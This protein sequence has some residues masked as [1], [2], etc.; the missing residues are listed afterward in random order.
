MVIGI[1]LVGSQNP[2]FSRLWRYWTEARSRNRTYLEYIAV[3]QRFVYWETALSIFGTDPWLGVGLGNYAFYFDDGL[4]I[5]PFHMQREI[6]R[7]ITPSE[8]RDRLITPKN[9]PARLLAETGVFGIAA[10]LAFLIAVVG[11]AAFL[12]NSPT[13]EQ[14]YYGLASILILIVF[15]FTV[16]SFEFIRFAKYVDHLWSHY[17]ISTSSRS[18]S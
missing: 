17:C 7:Q 15:A 1:G 11:C 4:P 2:Y 9:L 8:G 18:N 13:E 6:V 14:Q 3:E 5:R 10:F 12:W 16:F